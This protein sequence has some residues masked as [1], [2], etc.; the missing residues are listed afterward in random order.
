MR[1]LQLTIS[2]FGPYVGEQTFD[3][4]KLGKGGLYLITGDT[5][6]G[7][8][9][10]FDAITYALYGQTSSQRRDPAMLRSKYANDTTPTEVCLTFQY[11]DKQYTIK[12]NPDYERANKR[13]TG[14]TTQKAAAELIYPDGKVITKIK[15]V[16]LAIETILGIDCNQFSQIAMIA[17]GDFLKLLLA[18]TDERMAIFRHIFKT[19]CYAI[20][21]RR[22]K[23]DSLQLERECKD[24]KAS[25]AQY[26][27]GVLCSIDSC[28][29][30]E[31]EKAKKN[32]C[33][34]E[35]TLILI[36]KLI[37]K[38]K[39]AQTQL[40]KA[41]AILS[42]QRDDVKKNIEKANDIEKAKAD[43]NRNQE[44][45][46]TQKANHKQY[47]IKFEEA[48]LQQP[49]INEY[50]E[51]IAKINVVLKDYDIYIELENNL[52]KQQK[53]LEKAE[54][55]QKQHLKTYTDAQT[56]KED[57]EK[58][59]KLYEN[60]EADALKLEHQLKEQIELGKQ[61]KQ[62]RDSY[63]EFLNLKEE[64]QKSSDKYQT[65][66]NDYNQIKSLYDLQYQTYLDAQA[67]ILADMLQS[68]TPCP[69]C[70][71]TEHPHIATKPAN[72][73]TKQEL[74]QLQMKVNKATQEVNKASEKSGV[75]KGNMEAKEKNLCNELQKHTSDITIDTAAAF[76]QEKLN[77]LSASVRSGKEKNQEL[78]NN[79]NLLKQ[80]N[81][82]STQAKKDIESYQ[83]IQNEDAL[84]VQSINIQMKHFQENMSQIKDKL[85][86][87]SKAIAIKQRDTWQSQINE[88]Q[89]TF[90]NI[91]K[92]IQ[93]S[94]EKLASLKATIKEIANR[95]TDTKDININAEKELLTQLDRQMNEMEVKEKKLHNYIVTNETALKNIQQNVSNL[96]DIEKKYAWLK[97]LSDTA[98]GNISGK[99]RVVLET[100]I[101]MNYFDRI[102][103]RANKR[104][105][106]MTNGQ[107]DLIRA[108]EADN[109]KQK[110]GLDLNVIDHYNGSVR[111]VKSLS[112]GESFKASLAL[113]LGLSDEIQ[114]SAGGIKLDTMFIDEGFGSLD[115]E[116]LSQ[117]FK[118]LS[119]LADNNR[120]IGIIS[121]VAEL[122]QKIDKQIVI[123]KDKSGG[124][125]AEIIV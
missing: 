12:R 35:E 59:I 2:A 91:Q 32:E 3:F 79:I 22:L 122:K 38:D 104:F 33:T 102:I 24:I 50:Q 19:E 11:H 84:A 109:K 64:Y 108:K 94:N 120:L 55:N 41:K 13:G 71:S 46:T 101:Q 49:F 82:E 93:Q 98:N 111:S 10:I 51:K 77:E 63:N 7:K 61:F 115:E 26:V 96:I 54:Y 86:Y 43:L 68:G 37:E 80:Y 89:R 67:G 8:T 53:E 81:N 42:N 21:Q 114:A 56:K 105:M 83:K 44:L 69:V 60:V 113:A 62:F 20:L 72:A 17:Q 103:A 40:E 31:L 23:E 100:Y 29:Y 57:L 30:L 85:P 87:E 90:D 34:T 52:K 88:I 1:P 48:K 92:T 106:I 36:E 118:A 18:S 124:S 5:G 112:G 123:K 14:T 78:K 116:S 9:T 66:K 76:I 74:D 95:L 99:D 117:A 45:L 6:A 75:L 73:P 47:E 58:Q 119:Q 121:H 107:Y 28:D 25:I 125:S 65:I 15:D 97:A 4:T 70:G 110:S 16:T 39:E 27:Q